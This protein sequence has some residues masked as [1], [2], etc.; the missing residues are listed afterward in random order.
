MKFFASAL[1]FAATVL[2]LPSASCDKGTDSGEVASPPKTQ[3]ITY[4]QASAK[5]G[6]DAV[7]SCCNKQT[8]SGSVTNVNNGLLAGVLSNAIAGG[9]GSDGLGLFD[10]CSDLSLGG[11]S[12]S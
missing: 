1:L 10:G 3:D 6:N 7:V 11:K 5:C 12:D 8:V 9:P 2:A 4:E